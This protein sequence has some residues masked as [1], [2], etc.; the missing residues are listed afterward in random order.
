M[1]ARVAPLTRFVPW[2]WFLAAS[3][4]LVA[5]AAWLFQADSQATRA[6]QLDRLRDEAAAAVARVEASAAGLTRDVAQGRGALVDPSGAFLDPPEP[7]PLGR[8]GT[9]DTLGAYDAWLLERASEAERDAQ[10]IDEAARLYRVA[11]SSAE[12]S[13]GRLLARTRLAALYRRR[14]DE[15]AAARANRSA[16]DELARWSSRRDE[17]ALD[18]ATT[19]EAL[20]ERSL[21]DTDAESLRAD[22]L[23]ALG[24]PDEAIALGL[25]RDADLAD[26]GPIDVRRAELERIEALRPIVAEALGTTEGLALVDGALVAWAVEGT[27]GIRIGRSDLP[28]LPE[29]VTLVDDV[30]RMP[31]AGDGHQE[32]RSLGPLLPSVSVVA[33]LDVARAAGELRSRQ[34]LLLFGVFALLGLVGVA[35]VATARGLRRE[36]EAAAQQAAFLARVGHD[37]RTPL[38][39]IRMYAETVSSGRAE[40]DAQAREFAG[41]V[42][43]EAER[44]GGM[45]ASVLDLARTGTPAALRRE[46]IDCA[47]LVADT[48]RAFGT[49][50]ERAGVVLETRV[51]V[52]TPIVDGDPDALRGVLGNL[53]ENC[54]HHAATGGWACVRLTGGEDHVS[55][56]VEDRGPGLPP[57]LGERVFDRFVRGAVTDTRGAGLGLALVREVA[58]SH[59]GGVSVASR[60]EGGT[61]F[62]L[63]LPRAEPLESSP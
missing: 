26:R 48:T 20:V 10:M 51:E 22:L 57:E 5:L 8:L 46:R 3:L 35:F 21:G 31:V 7:R 52:E 41:V 49:L 29:S 23:S 2:L 4:G 30:D 33:S 6:R 47:A 15:A 42:A 25:L 62:E 12:D 60:A 45:V 13:G 43:G 54:L 50:F 61:R 28:A 19:V 63:R 36:R 11:G 37:L 59:G 9:T 14:G 55:L 58:E 39:V 1:S 32:R 40:S 34:T 27:D 53:L 38:S 24:T 17:T 56:V 44:L 18:L 16:L